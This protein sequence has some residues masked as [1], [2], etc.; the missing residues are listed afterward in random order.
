MRNQ[1]SGVMLL[2]ALIAILIFSLGILGVV[3]MQASAVAATRDAK[4]RTDAALLANELIGQ[5][6][7]GNRDGIA[8]QTN[9][10]GDDTDGVGG[11]GDVLTDGPLYSAWRNRVR[12]TLPGSDLNEPRVTVRPGV[13][14]PPKTSSTVNIQ[15]R[16]RAPNDSAAH[17]YRVQVDI[18]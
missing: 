14:G 11:A 15:V 7:A 17:V 9:F 2:E 3:G 5:M 1:Q 18:I 10:Q 16:W 8:L 12:A 13:A 4:Y 6:M